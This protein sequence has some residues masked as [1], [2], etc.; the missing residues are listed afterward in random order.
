[1][2]PLTGQTGGLTAGSLF[3]VFRSQVAELD[4]RRLLFEC[5]VQDL[6]RDTMSMMKEFSRVFSRARPVAASTT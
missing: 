1:M 2:T 6:S 5:Q 3:I 4:E